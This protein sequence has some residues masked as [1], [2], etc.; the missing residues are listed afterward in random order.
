[1]ARKY[2][3]RDLRIRNRFITLTFWTCAAWTVEGM[4][5]PKTPNTHDEIQ[6]LYLQKVNALVATDRE[7]LIA[8]ITAEY[9]SV[10]SASARP[11]HRAAA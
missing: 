11:E 4:N 1:M 2:C 9:A 10:V 5:T 7:H 3:D 8:D 6:D